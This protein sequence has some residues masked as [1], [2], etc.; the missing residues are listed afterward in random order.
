MG[1]LS[2]KYNPGFLSDDDLVA[3][4]CVRT[5]E[6]ELL[7][8]VLRECTGGSNPHQIVIGPRG[9]GKTSLLLRV[10]AEVGRDAA[11]GS[12]FFPIVFAE[13]SYEVA[14]AG[15]FW[16]E[17]LTNL[18]AQAPHG[19]DTPDLNRTAAELR[20]IRDDQSLSDRCLGALLDFADREDKRLVL[21]VENL[22]M[23]FGDMADPEAGWRLRKILQTEPRIVVFASATSRFAEIDNP[24]RALYDLF[25]VRTLHPLDTD[26]CA[27]LW[28]SVSGRHRAPET[29]RSLEI[30]TGGSPRL[31]SIVARFGAGLSFRD[32]MSDLFDLVDE[33]TEYFKSH[34]ESLPA[35]ERRVYLAL[36]TLWKPA[37][38]RE[39]ADHARIE[40]STCSAQLARLGDRGVVQVA[41]GSARRKQYYLTERLYNIYYLLRRRR[42]PDRLVEALIHF[43]ESFYSPAELRNISDRMVRD[44]AGLGEETRSLHRIALAS[45]MNLPSL[46]EYRNELLGMMPADPVAVTV[47]DSTP[48]DVV[49]ED[50]S[51]SDERTAE[52]LFETTAAS[53]VQAHAEETLVA[54]DE[55]VRRFG[56]SE[57]PGV[58]KWVAKALV[59][60]GVALSELNRPQAALETLDDVI[61]R[62][63]K[64]EIPSLL[65]SV[66]AAL[67]NRGTP[68]AVLNR[69]RD[70]LET[71]DE[72]IRRFGENDTVTLM[73]SVATA[74]VNKG[75]AFDELNQPHDALESYD[76]VIRRFG[77]SDVPAI[78]EWVANA[79]VN[80]GAALGTLQRPQDALESYDEVIRRFG[81]TE[82]PEL[83]ESV[84]NALANRGATLGTLSRP[85]DALKTCD[86]VVRR[87]GESETPALLK[88]V[89]FALT[90][91][92][93]ALGTLNRPQDALKTCDEVI[94]RFG[95]SDSPELLEPVATAL[96]NGGRVL[97]AMNRWQDSLEACDEVIRRFGKSDSPELLEPVATALVNR[98]G[99]LG[100]LNRPQDALEAFDEVVRRF[101]KSDSPRLLRSV[102]TALVNRGRALRALNRPQDALEIFNEVIR[103]FGES[104]DSRLF[105]RRVVQ[106]LCR[107]RGCARRAEPT[108]GSSGEPG[109]MWSAASERVRFLGVCGVDRE[110]SPEQSDALSE[111]AEPAARASWRPAKRWSVASGRAKTPLFWSR[112][113]PPSST[114]G[115]PSPR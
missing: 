13:E 107:Q 53:N 63:G 12:R 92:T 7:V 42:G 104:E 75:V 1:A 6:F 9:S 85:Q 29:I 8:E 49:Q 106:A 81:E 109:T 10:V 87:F 4:Y 73:A 64:S 25:R 39:I 32:L 52:E 62:F 2:R 103:R 79:L 97:G 58:V 71:F 22:N 113:R 96:V 40:T 23:L 55:I 60:R 54:C 114:K 66:A 57:I 110:G 3:S 16:L 69:P 27:I 98:G 100:A 51:E 89:A 70:T 80:K 36:A 94:R 37:T 19:E 11:L 30:L 33:H 18:A 34:I 31:I 41:G 115:L 24:D 67:V 91:K 86:E 48:A 95:K 88:S 38:T 76:E 14:T 108:T 5:T 93:A 77:E 90:N 43:M 26:Q 74:L 21:V 105:W 46:A 59:N 28:E 102:A 83:L 68:L 56:D 112:L 15:E 99:A 65:E 17:C 84:A 101:G 61:R 72:V 111:H 82:V 35:Q 47:R 44:A 50:G 20:T 45:L 78:L